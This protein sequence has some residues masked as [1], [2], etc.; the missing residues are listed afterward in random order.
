M[1]ILLIAPALALALACA[2]PAQAA[3]ESSCHAAFAKM[4][5]KSKGYITAKRYISMMKKSGRQMASSSRI[6]ESEFMSACVADVF[7]RGGY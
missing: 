2:A 5:A 6:S 3:T 1:R 4:D 7:Q